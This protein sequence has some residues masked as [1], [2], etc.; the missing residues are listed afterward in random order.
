[1]KF[2]TYQS[3]PEQ[4]V[5]NQQEEILNSV[6]N[7][8]DLFEQWTS[9]EHI[10]TEEWNNIWNVHVDCLQRYLSQKKRYFL[11]QKQYIEIIQSL[12]DTMKWLCIKS[13]NQW[14][15][16]LSQE[17]LDRYKTVI[18]SDEQYNRTVNP[19]AWWRELLSDKNTIT[20]WKRALYEYAHHQ[21]RWK[22]TWKKAA[23]IVALIW[24][25]SGD[26]QNPKQQTQEFGDIN[27]QKKETSSSKP[28][29]KQHNGIEQLKKEGKKIDGNLTQHHSSWYKFTAE[30]KPHTIM[31]IPGAEG[32]NA[33]RLH[34]LCI[35]AVDLL[36]RGR[37]LSTADT[38]YGLIDN[39]RYD[40]L[41]DGIL[42]LSARHSDHPF[43]ADIYL[44]PVL[45]GKPFMEVVALHE[46]IH[47]MIW[48]SALKMR[49]EWLTELLTLK[50]MYDQEQKD[51]FHTNLA[52]AWHIINSLMIM[53]A[54]ESHQGFGEFVPRLV[55]DYKNVYNTGKNEYSEA[56][57]QY[58]HTH[59][60]WDFDPYVIMF[61][62]RM[63][64][65]QLSSTASG[66]MTPKIKQFFALTDQAYP[67]T[68]YYRIEQSQASDTEKIKQALALWNKTVKTEKHHHH[69]HDKGLDEENDPIEIPPTTDIWSIKQGNNKDK[70]LPWNKQNVWEDQKKQTIDEKWGSSEKYKEKVPQ[71]NKEVQEYIARRINNISWAFEELRKQYG[72]KYINYIDILSIYAVW[73]YLEEANRFEYEKLIPD[74]QQLIIQLFQEIKQT[75]L[76]EY[77]PYFNK[78]EDWNT[79]KVRD[80]VQNKI[81]TLLKSKTTEITTHLLA[82]IWSKQVD[83]SSVILQEDKVSITIQEL[84]TES[85]IERLPDSEVKGN[86]IN[87]WSIEHTKAIIEATKSILKK[88]PLAWEKLLYKNYIKAEDIVKIF[89]S[90]TIPSWVI[91]EQWIDNFVMSKVKEQHWWKTLK[92]VMS[93]MMYVVLEDI[94][95]QKDID[96]TLYM[97]FWKQADKIMMSMN[98]VPVA[99][100]ISICVILWILILYGQQHRQKK[101]KQSL[102]NNPYT[103]KK[104]IND[105]I[106][107]GNSFRFRLLYITIATS[108]ILYRN[109]IRKDFND[110]SISR[111]I[112]QIPTSTVIW[113]NNKQEFG[114]TSIWLR[115]FYLVED[116]RAKKVSDQVDQ[117]KPKTYD[118]FMKITQDVYDKSYD[119]KA[120]Y[121]NTNRDDYRL[122]WEIILAVLSTSLITFGLIK[123]TSNEYKTIKNFKKLLTS[124]KPLTEENL[125]KEVFNDTYSEKAKKELLNIRIHLWW[126]RTRLPS[127]RWVGRN[128]ISSVNLPTGWNTLVID[129]QYNILCKAWR[130]SENIKDIFIKEYAPSLKAAIEQKIPIKILCNGLPIEYYQEPDFNSIIEYKEVWFTMVRLLKEAL[131]DYNSKNHLNETNS[132]FWWSPLVLGSMKPIIKN[133]KENHIRME[134]H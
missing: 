79:N 24:A 103:D 110:L 77:L 54:Y 9:A 78:Y 113:L 47:Q 133:K 48:V 116:D 121:R 93:D 46:V 81:E 101:A 96:F 52:Y 42:G 114:N 36:Q 84:L 97:R 30:G 123:K 5:R 130:T 59:S 98:E 109:I 49:N 85:C 7:W 18:N 89:Q 20:Q 76:A 91:V 50:T 66:Y 68:A 87:M 102:Q 83:W 61:L 57:F 60:N 15:S 58:L 33:Q 4:K 67:Q 134:N 41:P 13:Y 10:T 37:S 32:L 86:F 43:D 74:K 45:K 25:L 70:N 34:S 1:M 17:S 65:K 100:L 132:N 16:A 99:L 118:E 22:K 126:I 104:N 105:T 122:R 112:E 128:E 108:F 94:E 72:D 21:P 62:T 125:L 6:N 51:L 75:G 31:Q 2:S 14:V 82:N 8:W 71:N 44:D 127:T 119:I 28:S 80:L 23:T 63:H 27:Q 3:A 12:I 29:I 39:I 53:S 95:N 38:T 131:D 35:H 111:N 26:M 106:F 129:F 117:K 120:D 19:F 90:K 107:L 69:N 73:K 40:K 88:Y 124:G 64:S 11:Q 115:S 55:Y 56:L 92:K